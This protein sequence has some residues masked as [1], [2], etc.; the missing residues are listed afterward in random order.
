MGIQQMQAMYGHAMPQDYIAGS[1]S[2]SQ[3]GYFAPPGFVQ[4]HDPYLSHQLYQV[5]ASASL[6]CG[7]SCS[8][9]YPPVEQSF[10]S[11]TFVANDSIPVSQGHKQFDPEALVVK[12]PTLPDSNQ[13]WIWSALCCIVVLLVT[14][15]M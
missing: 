5:D 4:M 1:I 14:F 3:L 13:C 8:F 6:P 9:M 2:T 15:A 11:S 7:T 10:P 12:L